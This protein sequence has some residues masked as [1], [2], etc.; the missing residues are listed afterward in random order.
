MANVGSIIGGPR[1]IA[2]IGRRLLQTRKLLRGGLG[3]LAAFIGIPA[4]IVLPFFLPLTFGGRVVTGVLIVGSM[5]ALLVFI[6][7][8]DKSL[9]REVI[10]RIRATGVSDEQAARILVPLKEFQDGALGSDFVATLFP[11]GAY[12]MS[13]RRQLAGA[14]QAVECL[15]WRRA[16][17][18]AGDTNT[19]AR[20]ESL[21][22]ASL[23]YLAFADKRKL[24]YITLEARPCWPAL[25]EKAK[26]YATQGMTRVSGLPPQ[27]PMSGHGKELFS[28]VI[29][30]ATKVAALSREDAK[31]DPGYYEWKGPQGGVVYKP[32]EAGIIGEPNAPKITAAHVRELAQKFCDTKWLT[33][34]LREEWI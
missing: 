11:L 1:E 13:G 30:H 23:L 31:R 17:D 5:I 10:E 8:K 21:A 18:L 9:V 32:E 3:L 14:G 22:W 19:E 15:D 24:V 25:A 28:Q 34:R 16:A 2:S 29:E 7:S 6:F 20:I 27:H 4:G 33:D 12:I 26:R